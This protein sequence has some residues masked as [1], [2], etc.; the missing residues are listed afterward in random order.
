MLKVTGDLV[1]PTTMTGS[2]P[3]PSW[4]SQGL[5]GR[6]FKAALGDSLFREQYLDA[7]ATVIND[8]AMA[9]LDIVTDGDSRFDL[10]V[11]GKSWFFYPLE[12]LVGFG[13]YED[14]SPGF[15]E[16]IGIRPGHI[17]WEVQEAYQ[18]PVLTE[19]LTRG[20]LQYSALWKVAQRMT[21]KP[22]KFGTISAQSLRAMIW[23]RYY[24]SD[25]ELVLELCD[26]MNE[27]LRELVAA[28]C[29]LVQMEEPLLHY[30]ALRE[31][32][33]DKDLEFYIEAFNREVRGLDAEIWAHT[34]WG[35]PSQQRTSWVPPSYE[36]SI[37][38][39]LELDADVVTFECASS[40]GKD[41]PLFA[42]HETS[43]K[44]AIGVV[45]HT[46]A[47]V[48][49]PDLV[50]ERVRRALEYIPPERLIISTD[51]GFGREGLSRRIAFY[52]CVSLVLGTN[53]VRRELGLPEAEVRAADPRFA[54]GEVPAGS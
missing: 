50:A 23:N 10:E 18:P 42:K 3:K 47:V 28:G 54:F 32:T 44:I 5:H 19:R 12:R 24:P 43:K 15:M 52:K 13:A 31:E 25:K 21:D 51:C 39:L 30:Y 9:G 49:S 53:I 16:N 1:L 8:Q 14:T 40:D 33:T 27:E 45:N 38:Y 22:V 11:G 36:R 7:V 48:E 35:N 26:I 46:N 41:L 6:P 17:L 2:Y 29:P 4:Y 37:P 34:C 20:P